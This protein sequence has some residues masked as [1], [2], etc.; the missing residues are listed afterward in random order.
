MPL[1]RRR[2]KA[3]TA[4]LVIPAEPRPLGRHIRRRRAEGMELNVNLLG[5]AILGEE[6]A[7]RRLEGVRRLLARPDVDYVSVKLSGVSSRIRPLAFDA[8]VDALVERLRPLY[9]DAARTRKFVNL[10]MEEYHDLALT[11]AVFRRVLDEHDVDAGIVL[12]A[13]LPDAHEAMAGL[14][15][16]G[17]RVKVRIVK[18]ANL[19]MERV[20][21]EVHGWP[22]AP[23]DDKRDV[24]ASY[25][26]LLDAALDGTIRVGVASHNLFDVA[27][28]LT[29]A[30]HRDALDRLDVEMLE[31]M[32]PA[33]S[34]AV[35][36]RTS[37]LRLYAPVVGA[38]DFDA[39]IAYLAR[40]LE[41]N[42]QPGNFLREVFDLD[43]DGEEWAQQEAR[44]RE[45]VARR[46]TVST[47][48]RRTQDRRRPPDPGPAVFRN[49]PDTDF[50]LAAN[51]AWAAEHLQAPPPDTSWEPADLATVETALATARRAGQGWAARPLRERAELVRAIGDV[52]AGMRGRL[53]AAMVH[54]G[55][56]T[57]PEADPEV[58][59]A[60]DFARWYAACAGELESLHAEGVAM[61]PYGVTVVVPPWNF[62]VA[63]PAGGVLA[64]L[65]T[66]SAVI[67]K[68]APETVACGRLVAEACWEA[69]IPRDVLQLVTCADD[70]AGRALVTGGDG[71][72]LTGSIETARLFHSWRPSMRLHA[73]TSGKNA[74]VVTAAADIDAAVKDVVR[75]AFG[76]AGQKCSAA[77][78][79][80]CEAA[81][82]DDPRFL[83]Q[84][85]DATRSL[86][87]APA[88]DLRAD[89]GP[90]IHPPEG[91]LDR[92]LRTLEPGESWLVEPRQLDDE[93]RLWSPG[94]RLGV[95]PGSW[96]HRTECFGPVLGVMRAPDLDTAIAWQNATDFGLTA[97][98]HTLD[99]GEVARWLDRVE[100]GNCYVN[101]QT[102]GAI[103]RR[104]PFGGWKASS[105]GPTAKAGGPSYV[106]T[107]GR[108]H[109]AGE[110]AVSYRDWW[111]K[112]YAV[113]HDPT[114]LVAERNVLRYRPL[115]LV[116]VRLGPGAT[117]VDAERVRLASEVTGTPIVVSS[118]ADEDDAAFAIRLASLGGSRLRVVGGASDAVL[119]AAHLAGLA[120]DDAPV[121]AHGRVELLRWVREQAI[122]ET[123]HRYGNLRR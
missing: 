29:V 77:S 16:L 104:Q 41:E 109:D 10:D 97:G 76:H 3:E 26:R 118:A 117:D 40:R 89:V 83:R 30:R 17:P 112:H 50:A 80:I 19:A 98:I 103:V 88:A 9:A 111:E 64:A 108:W 93:G 107:L 96:F 73:E 84:L 8:T 14:A 101:R 105:V 1:V 51:R 53:V 57:V 39:S 81:V 120:V 71:V 74:L 114:G 72:I 52:L 99:R 63:I 5:E 24:D 86:V 56:K 65:V 15:G 68:P 61:E 82:H 37:S 78:L 100:A 28:A 113:E 115:P 4:G 22:Q 47:E 49:E 25:K 94:V 31:G 110:T 18:G 58:S 34:A 48:P 33:Q 44:F 20:D 91:P 79:V 60:V 87:V 21:A 2:V 75:S 106:L 102:T 54:E 12:Q 70:E 121:V 13:Y 46:R 35:R 32:A 27:W 36:R 43:P 7:T 59:E 116:V 119:E 85:A 67:L 122:S 42:T 11:T 69:G 62:P 95:R 23:Y 55:G 6:E 66:G 45:A 38:D 90:L 92:A 123:A